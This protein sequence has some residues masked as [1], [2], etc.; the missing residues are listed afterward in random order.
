MDDVTSLFAATAT[1]AGLELTVEVAA[2]VPS[3][4]ESDENRIRQV[5]LNLCQRTQ[6]TAE[7]RCPGGCRVGAGPARTVRTAV[8][9]EDT[10]IGIN[11]DRQDRIFLPFTQVDAFTTRT[12]GGTGLGLSICRLTPA[13]WTAGWN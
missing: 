7:R 12:Y 10:G 5:L 6:F 4:V 8:R 9:R 2:D 3:A 13:T 1:T 11:V